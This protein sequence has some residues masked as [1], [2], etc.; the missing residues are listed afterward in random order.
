MEDDVVRDDRRAAALRAGP[1]KVHTD[2]ATMPVPGNG[3]PK[4]A[5]MWVYVRD[6]RRSGSVAAPAA[7]FAYT[8]NR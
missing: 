2:D 3:Q 5:R 6:D 4:T 7:W 8:P 1:G